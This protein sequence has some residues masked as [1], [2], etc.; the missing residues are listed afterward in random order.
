MKNFKSD[1]SQED[2]I[3][4]YIFLDETCRDAIN[5]K[6]DFIKTRK[7]AEK[8]WEK[9]TQEDREKLDK[10]ISL[11][12]PFYVKFMKTN[13]NRING[14][15]LF[16]KDRMAKAR[17]QLNS[18]TISECA[19]EWK[20]LDS[21]I[22]KLYNDYAKF[23]REE[24]SDIILM[25]IEIP[26]RKVRELWGPFKY[27][28]HEISSGNLKLD[29]QFLVNAR[30]MWD[31]LTE[32][33]RSKYEQI[34]AKEHH[35]YVTKMLQFML[36]KKRQHKGPNSAFNLFTIDIE[37]AYADKEYRD[38]ELF[39]FV[40]Q[41]WNELDEEIKNIYEKCAEWEET[42]F[43]NK[44]IKKR[45]NQNK[46]KYDIKSKEPT[47]KRT[48]CIS[49]KIVSV[50]NGNKKFDTFLKIN[51]LSTENHSIDSEEHKIKHSQ[52]QSPRKHTHGKSKKLIIENSDSDYNSG[53]KNKKILSKRFKN[54][55]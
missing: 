23:I 39:D 33:E 19:K 22:K 1:Y 10:K 14:Y 2:E 44:F 26:M 46:Y 47:K 20:I 50:N 24:R 11:N 27:F 38:M 42:E 7:N 30:E 49:S 52:T 9:M 13:P 3:L 55:K 8:K 6:K 36:Q 37:K 15:N 16:T 18:K 12:K 29:G 25:P 17:E 45:E 41:K 4:K 40:F 54:I 53:S 5:Q 43:Y 31:Y 28:V 48:S 32:E 51:N 34:A 21:E 35:E